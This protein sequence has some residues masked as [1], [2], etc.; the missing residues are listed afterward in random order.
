[1]EMSTRN[2]L[3]RR[4]ASKQKSLVIAC[5]PRSCSNTSECTSWSGSTS[6][7]SPTCETESDTYPTFDGYE[8]LA[9]LGSGTFAAVYLAKRQSDGKNV[10]LKHVSGLPDS[11]SVAATRKELQALQ[12]FRHPHIIQAFDFFEADF[13][14]CLVLEYFEG[15]TLDKAAK[16]R[17][18]PE[19]VAVELFQMLAG[20]VLT[21]HE[22]RIV[23]RDVKP[24]NIMVSKDLTD[25]RLMDFN[26]AKRL[27]EGGALT[28][29]GTTLFHPP[30]VQQGFES[31][32]ELSDIWSLGIC[33][34]F[35]LAGKLPRSVSN[36][37]AARLQRDSGKLEGVSESCKRVI[38][39]CLSIDKKDRAGLAKL[40]SKEWHLPETAFKRR[41]ESSADPRAEPTWPCQPPTWARAVSC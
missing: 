19:L 26:S 20:A 31:P 12:S 23:H 5:A 28:M 8:V 37:S 39:Q 21:L 38:H 2:L 17:P 33:F 9:I 35:M 22:R 18:F 32:S 10:A 1:M 13:S 29:A 34:Y 27:V 36:A 24:E 7:E 41:S 16:Q 30:E 14:V 15:F 6:K 25:L 3:A 4:P 11:E 40:I